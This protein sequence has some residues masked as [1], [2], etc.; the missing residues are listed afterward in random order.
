MVLTPCRKGHFAIITFKNF[1]TSNHFIMEKLAIGIAAITLLSF[2]IVYV[3]SRF[4]LTDK[5]D[6]DK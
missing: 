1:L 5:D 4:L 3:G 6:A 2:V